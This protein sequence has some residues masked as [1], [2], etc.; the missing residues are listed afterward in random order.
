MAPSVTEV[1]ILSKVS[2]AESG[3]RFKDLAGL[4]INPKIITDNIA[5]LQRSGMIEKLE[6]NPSR[7]LYRIT[8]GGRRMLEAEGRPLLELEEAKVEAELQ[9]RG[10]AEAEG[11]NLYKT[12]WLF[13]D[14]VHVDLAPQGVV[15]GA[16]RTLATMGIAPLYKDVLQPVLK[17]TE[18]EREYAELL[19][20]LFIDSVDYEEAFGRDPQLK[21]F[22]QS[23]PPFK[24]RF[25]RGAWEAATGFEDGARGFDYL[26]A[27]DNET[28]KGLVQRPFI[29]RLEKNYLEIF[30]GECSSAAGEEVRLEGGAFVK[31]LCWM[32]LKDRCLG[33]KAYSALRKQLLII[34]LRDLGMID[35]AVTR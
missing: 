10:M 26:A 35:M 8:R 12:S 27:F 20:H 9:A 23:Y 32:R 7:P 18:D 24:A 17:P 13:R 34:G 11:K 33:R 19:M 31:M 25:A 2:E 1:R 21:S 6:T 16:L 15:K 5:E 3:A 30:E 22:A 28:V 4:G 29:Q 14:F